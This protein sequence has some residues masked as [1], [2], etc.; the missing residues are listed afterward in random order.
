MPDVRRIERWLPISEIG[1]ES[2][3]ERTPM[4]PDA[5]AWPKTRR[6]VRIVNGIDLT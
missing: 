2:T 4:T 5:E 3:R 1:V 6:G